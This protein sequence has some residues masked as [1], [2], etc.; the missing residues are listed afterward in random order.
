MIAFLK[1]DF[2]INLSPDRSAPYKVNPPLWLPV[3]SNSGDIEC[4]SA[5]NTV[6]PLFQRSLHKHMLWIVR[7]RQ[8]YV[9]LERTRT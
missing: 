2:K 4:G 8:E 7:R 3:I 1:I 5:P 9:G 6:R